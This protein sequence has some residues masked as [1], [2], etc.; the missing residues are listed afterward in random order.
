VMGRHI[1]LFSQGSLC[2]PAF[3]AVFPQIFAVFIERRIL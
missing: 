2:K 1:D 3:P